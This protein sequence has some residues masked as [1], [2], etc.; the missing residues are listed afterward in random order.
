MG[1]GNINEAIE[2]FQ[3]MG[4]LISIEPYG[5]GHINDTYLLTFCIGETGKLHVILQ[6]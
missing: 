3:Y 1:K 6:R 2:H 5:N 4:E